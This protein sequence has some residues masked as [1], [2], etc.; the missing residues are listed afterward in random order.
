MSRVLNLF[1]FLSG[2]EEGATLAEIA[3]ELGA[4]KSTLRDSL[5]AL[6]AE[7][8]LVA[9]EGRFRLGPTAFRLGA[10]LIS[11]WSLPMNARPFLRE[12]AQKTGESVALA[13]IDREARRFIFIDGVES[14]HGVRFVMQ[15][16]RGDALYVGASGRVLLAFQDEAYR[17]T[18]LG[19]APFRA[20]TPRTVTSAEGLRRVLE[21]VRAEGVAVSLGESMKD[22]AALAA[23]IFG[24]HGNIVAAL[25]VAGPL[26]RLEPRQH[27]QASADRGR[28][29]R[30]GPDR[31][32]LQRTEA[33]GGGA[34]ARRA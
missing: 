34:P 1:W 30:F 23:P 3:A 2:R 26:S 18:Y 15:P 25:T 24:P 27:Q 28:P 33:A 20:V 13:Q 16:G 31:A 22:G 19:A 21:A 29:G 11:R 17:E 14:A 8:Y 12:L 4:P 6:L 32:R 9:P 5:P 10:R 7:G